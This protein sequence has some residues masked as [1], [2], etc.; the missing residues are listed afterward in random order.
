MLYADDSVILASGSTPQEVTNKLSQDL[1]SR[2]E[3]F[4]DN[5]LSLHIGKTEFILFGSRT[6]L[7]RIEQCQIPFNGTVIKSKQSV[8]YL[9]VILDQCLSGEEMALYIIK[10]ISCKLRFL[11]RQR[12]FLTQ[13]LRRD[14]SVALI[15]S[16]FDYCRLAWQTTLSKVLKSK[17]QVLQNKM[18]RFI[19]DLP[20]R[21]HI[22][23]EQLKAVNLLEVESRIKQ[24][25]LN[26]V[27]KFFT[28]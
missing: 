7:A 24:I 2:S 21:S 14:L 15:Q 23:H 12:R 27:L 26:Y 8:K 6:R 1:K 28:T 18:V 17:L 13:Q 10:K 25:R 22:G 11:Y 3:W 4:V 19:L 5:K 20:P 16:H 9:G